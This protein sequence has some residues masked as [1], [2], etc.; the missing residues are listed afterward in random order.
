MTGFCFVLFYVGLKIRVTY[1]FFY[2]GHQLEAFMHKC[3]ELYFSPNGAKWCAICQRSI[4]R[5]LISQTI[6]RVLWSSSVFNSYVLPEKFVILLNKAF[7]YRKRHDWIDYE[8]ML[9]K[10]CPLAIDLCSTFQ[11]WK[12]TFEAGSPPGYQVI[13]S[14]SPTEDPVARIRRPTFS[15]F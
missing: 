8:Q 6:I 7:K 4:K 2:Q 1:P 9:H 13:K 14:S 10:I 5:F 11:G 12:L 15:Q 3:V